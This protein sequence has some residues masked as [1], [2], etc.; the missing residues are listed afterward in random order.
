MH[1][2]LQEFNLILVVPVVPWM[3]IR[4]TCPVPTTDLA[5]ASLCLACALSLVRTI[6]PFPISFLTYFLTISQ[7]GPVLPTS[8]LYFRFWN[9]IEIHVIIHKFYKYFLCIFIFIKKKLRLR[10]VRP[11]V[12][13][14]KKCRRQIKSCIFFD[15]LPCRCV[16]AEHCNMHAERKSNWNYLS[17]V[18]ARLLQY[19]GYES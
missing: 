1:L 13:F 2:R 19:F 16:S 5:C 18:I 9:Y 11:A 14:L 3:E 15:T 17:T 6:Q 7:L 8:V 10:I 4:Q 12:K